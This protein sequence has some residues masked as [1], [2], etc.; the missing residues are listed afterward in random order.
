M[1]E[2]LALNHV[3]VNIP[4]H[5]S[6]IPPQKLRSVGV[7]SIILFGILGLFVLNGWAFDEE[8]YIPQDTID[9]VDGRLVKGTVRFGEKFCTTK[10]YTCLKVKRSDRWAQLFPD[11]RIRDMVKRVNRMNTFLKPGMVLAVPDS[12]EKHDIYELSPFAHHIEPQGEPLVYIDSHQLAWAA[13]DAD[14]NL[15]RWGPVSTGTGRCSYLKDGCDTPTGKFRVTRM[16]GNDC[17]SSAYPKRLW[18][19]DGGAP[20]PYCM[21]FYKGYAL[22]GADELPGRPSTHGCVDLFQEDAKWLHDYFVEAPKAGR[23]GTLILIDRSLD[24]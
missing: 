4:L 17:I 23:K 21:H 8:Q 10:G 13:Y 22:H 1:I 19:P 20:M 2:R 7:L 11:A 12:L 15:A 3:V 14:G 9:G 24:K 6:R 5:L 16:Q 18:G